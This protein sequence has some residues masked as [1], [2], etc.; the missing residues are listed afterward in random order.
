LEGKDK[1]LLSALVRKILR[2]DPEERP[3]AE[4]LFEDEFLT[5]CHG[6]NK[7]RVSNAL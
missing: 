4:G 7:T 2:W 6:K 5:Q 1:A 3:S